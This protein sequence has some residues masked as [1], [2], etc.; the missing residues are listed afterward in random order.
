MQKIK[1]LKYW[2]FLVALQVS[3]LL[4]SNSALAQVQLPADLKPDYLPDVP[5][6]TPEDKIYGISG[7]I[8]ITI[9]QLIG[10]IAVIL[11]IYNGFKYTISRGEEDVIGETKGNLG[12]IAA[13]LVLIAISYVVIR[14]VVK[15]TLFVDEI[16]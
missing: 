3:T 1:L 11:I 9:S 5:G 15:A 13:G 10:G 7:D 12:Y 16:N 14:F 6:V 4:F 2:I 8:I